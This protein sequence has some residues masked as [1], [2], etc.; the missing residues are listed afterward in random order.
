[1][2]KMLVNKGSVVFSA[3]LL[4]I[5]I[6]VISYIKLPRESSPEIK[7][8]YI[9]ITTV[10]PGVAAADVENLVTRII[11]DEID[12]VEG[13][14]E[15]SSSS[16]QNLSFIFTKFASNISVETAL[17]KIKERVDRAKSRLPE[18]AEEPSVQELSS[19]N[20]PILMVSLSHP[21]GLAQ[22]DNA[23]EE[24]RKELRRVK[25]VLDVEIAGN[26]EKEVSVELDPEKLNH[27]GLTVND[28]SYAI[29]FAN[30]A[31]PGGLLKNNSLNYSLSVNSEIKDP[32]Q[33]EDIIVKS[34]P[35]K[36]P[37]R[38]I[39]RVSFSF[40]EQKTISR[41]NGEPAISLS[42]TKRSGENIIHMVDRAQK[43][44]NNKIKQG[45]LPPG[46]NIAYS[47][48]ESKYIRLIISDL[49]NNMFTGFLLVL[50]VTI[51]FLGFVNSLFVSL[52]IPFSMLLSFFILDAMGVTLNM[53]VLFSLILALGMLVDNGIV[54]VENIFRHG[55]MGKPIVQASIDGASEVAIPIF[56]STLTTCV[57]FFP[58]IFMPDVMGDFMK[59]IPITVIVVL[60]A[61]LF[62]ALTI[63]PV[64]C[65]RFLKISEEN[66]KKIIEG[67][68]RFHALQRTY[69]SILTKAVDHAVPVLIASLLVVLSGM[70]LYGRFGK[71][72]IFFPATD[73]TDAIITVEMPQG[74]PLQKT[75]SVISVIENA[76]PS[77]PMSL[78]N[79]QA[80][81]GKAGDG[82]MFSGM[83]EEFNKG[84]V[85]LSFKPFIE[86]LIP[87]R[88]AIDSLK[89]RFS[90]FVG[91]KVT[92]ME[93]ES[94]PPSGHDI[95][96]DIIGKDYKVLGSYADTLQTLLQ[97]YP[98]LKLVKSD[99]EAAKPEIAITIDRLKA[100]Y[101]GL[102][103]QEI[104]STIRN[105]IN[106]AIIGKYRQDE[107]E[108]DIVVR[109]A[110]SDR[111]AISDLSRLH[112]V[113][114]DGIR[115]PL[116]EVASITPTSSVG[117]IKR[118]D[119]RRSVGVWGDFKPG[120][121]NKE[122]IKKTVD[123]LVHRLQL[124][125]GYAIESGAGSEMRQEAS[126]FLV[127]AFMIAMFLIAIILIAQFN[128]ILQSG[129]ILTSVFLSMGGVFWGY[130]IGGQEFIIIM[131]GIGCISL[132]GVAVNNGIIL[133]D[134]TNLLV[135]QGMLPIEAVVEAGKTRL[136]PVL[137]TAI[138]TVLGLLPMAFG[139]SIDI[140]PA[141]FGIQVGSEMSDFWKAFA[142]A[143]VYGLSFATVM[144]LI[145]VPC[146]MSLYF[147]VFP[148]KKIPAPI[149]VH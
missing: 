140:H 118:R 134:Y 15:L 102:S 84:S 98:E 41:F 77:V 92:V 1:M 129:I 57:A 49:E 37:L 104:A 101:Y 93:Q 50:I 87:G 83:G 105:A 31:I 78:D 36:I 132:A 55:S 121:Q 131:S 91:A 99:F 94:G 81:S 34:G 51:F 14:I 114:G 26:L 71:E 52:A 70:F 44:I 60:A 67:S 68:G 65:S 16:Q 69:T 113:D 6:G 122:D 128:S 133:V 90:R 138:T 18:D 22:I 103:T 12:G 46:T 4:I 24:L 82:E 115:I 106:G 107:E 2:I 13:I 43:L 135:K 100:A 127:R 126:I 59:Y 142:W 146:M 108:F 33:F 96:Y 88:T 9:F 80:T 8:P 125:R 32:R 123:S 75:D 56:S 30:I 38:D 10:F 73:P 120:I 124:P 149:P 109:Y 143:M 39:G 28:V 20:W 3:A 53:V 17:R 95:S 61:S 35:V 116:S 144:T 137:L 54:I 139:I 110:D 27:Y 48:D 11:E 29:Q 145:V 130:L 119:L 89:S 23:A 25:G 64:F 147:K 148:P 136:R 40:A 45:R 66:R 97:H 112:I 117:V 79:V 42:L 19:S 47:Y 5:I 21:G 141:T 62:V 111:D 76:I 74:T 72:P 63:N 58:I 86:R 85:R 7:Q